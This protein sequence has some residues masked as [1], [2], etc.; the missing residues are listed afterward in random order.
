[1]KDSDSDMD[2]DGTI[3]MDEDELLPQDETLN[4]LPPV[5]SAMVVMAL[6]IQGYTLIG[7]LQHDLKSAIHI[8]DKGAASEVFIQAAACVQWGK[9]VMTLGQ[10]IVLARFD[11]I[12]R[13][14]ISMALMTVGCV[15]PPLFVFGFQASWL[16]TVFISYATIGF[17]LGIFE[18]CFMSAIV[19]LGHLTKSW[20][21]MGFPAAFGFVNIVGR[22]LVAE[23]MPVQVLFWYIA[24]GVPVSAYLFYRI[25]PSTSNITASGPAKSHAQ[26]GIRASLRDWR[27]WLVRMIPFMLVNIVNHFVMESVMPAMF[28]AYNSKQVPMFGRYDNQ[29]LMD[30][31]MYFVVLAIFTM[32]GD[33]ISRRVGYC[34]ALNTYYSNFCALT[35]AV[36]CS[37]LGL[38]LTT[39]GIAIVGWFSVFLAFWGAGFIYSVTAK[40]I[41]N[42]VPKEHNLAAYSL[43]MFVGYAGAIAGS[44]LVTP[45]KES[46]CQ[47]ASY[48][49]MCL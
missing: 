2:S 22:I 41:D 36:F 19:P 40:Y 44:V 7:P 20:A 47:G 29:N 24:L 25:A 15:I 43:W 6:M 4:E 1:M 49:H 37:C 27:T 46:I 10:N 8:T 33:M 35:Y 17:A 21:I 23:G 38:Y 12:T 34:F 5:R 26:A 11:T 31:N 32:A 28:N 39:R 16:G 14:Y 45:V 9:F 42:F 13:V 48:E 3:E 18:P 30:K